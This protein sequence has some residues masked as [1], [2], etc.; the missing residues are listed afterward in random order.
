MGRVIPWKEIREK[1]EEGGWSYSALAR[2]Y[3]AAPATVSKRARKEQWKGA[4]NYR[5]EEPVG[6][7]LASAAR[8]LSASVNETVRQ[9]E[10]SVKAVDFARLGE[11]L[12]CLTAAGE[13][14]A[15]RGSEGE[16]ERELCWEAEWCS[17]NR[18]SAYTPLRLSF[19]KTV[20]MPAI[21]RASGLRFERMTLGQESKLTVVRA[22][23][24]FTHRVSL[25]LG[26]RRFELT[27]G[28]V[29]ET[30]IRWKP[31]L[32][33]AEAIPNS[34]SGQGTLKIVTY[35]RGKVLGEK[36]YGVALL[37][38]SSLRPSAE[39]TVEIVNDGA[40]QGWPEAI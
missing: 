38:P 3:G 12:Y 22:E 11:E 27:D 40:A 8:Q 31:P 14:W 19:G 39:L 35:D 4:G 9:E 24:R 21:P 37:V 7:C 23:E 34:G 10:V 17:E 28:A 1:Y 5:R 29:K 2:E 30:V 16:K 32:S 15:L 25:T 36:E 13:I 20:E 18:G 6:K 33:L 26:D